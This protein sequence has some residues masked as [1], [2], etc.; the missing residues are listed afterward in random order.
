M[1]RDANARL[2]HER[3][4]KSGESIE[5]LKRV[6]GIVNILLSEAKT[7]EPI[8]NALESRPRFPSWT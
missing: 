6:D 7:C 4:A 5:S 1:S 2:R 8:H 3:G